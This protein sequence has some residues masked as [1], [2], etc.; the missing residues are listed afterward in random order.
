[1][2]NEA[3]L[4]IDKETNLR[5]TTTTKASTSFST[6]T[7]SSETDSDSDDNVN[8]SNSISNSKNNNPWKGRC[9]FVKFPNFK[10]N[11]LEALL[12]IYK[13]LD[14]GNSFPMTKQMEDSINIHYVHEHVI[15]K[16]RHDYTNP[17]LEEMNIKLEEFMNLPGV[18]LYSTLLED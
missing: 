13:Q 4:Y 3:E 1:M 2:S 7:T 5:N 11:P 16:Q 9:H 10:S 8:N 17:T 14:D 15:Y 12:G 18:K 6:T